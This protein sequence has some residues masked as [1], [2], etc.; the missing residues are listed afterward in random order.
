MVIIW[1]ARVW[2]ISSSMAAKVVD[3]P[4]LEGPVINTNPWLALVNSCTIEGRFNSSI[5][6]ILLGTKRRAQE[7]FPLS[8]KILTL[9]LALSSKL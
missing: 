7:I 9:N 5:R 6:G 2:F 8:K 3:L 1:S 4:W